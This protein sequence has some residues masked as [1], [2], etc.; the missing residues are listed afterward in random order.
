MGGNKN[1]QGRTKAQRGKYSTPP[2]K[3]RHPSR[4]EFNSVHLQHSV[5]PPPKED[6]KTNSSD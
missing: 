1:L 2:S 5:P 4:G 6:R 3:R